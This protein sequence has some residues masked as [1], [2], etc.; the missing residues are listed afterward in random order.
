[1]IL[2]HFQFKSVQCTKCFCR[3]LP[4]LKVT[5]VT[6]APDEDFPF[7][8]VIVLQQNCVW[9]V[10]RAT[11]AKSPSI[12]EKW[13]CLDLAPPA[14]QIFV[15][16]KFM[17]GC[18]TQFQKKRLFLFRLSRHSSIALNIGPQVSFA[19]HLRVANFLEIGQHLWKWRP[20]HSKFGYASM[21]HVYA[22]SPAITGQLMTGNRNMIVGILAG[23][24]VMAN[25]RR[26]N[27]PTIWIAWS[28]SLAAWQRTTNTT[29]AIVVSSIRTSII[30]LT[31]LCI[32]SSSMRYV[33]YHSVTRS[34]TNNQ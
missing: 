16:S 15:R 32:L 25:E 23:N 13:R 31:R 18:A 8:R 29:V 6:D 22:V 34:H 21:R 28:A 9:Y 12:H 20:I 30:T 26:D 19:T 17:T 27:S 1:M 11:N 24:W 3:H 10:R 14:L 5:V 33:S 4:N 2:E 7:H